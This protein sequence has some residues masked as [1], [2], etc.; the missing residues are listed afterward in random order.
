MDVIHLGYSPLWI[1]YL[2]ENFQIVKKL[3]ELGAEVSEGVLIDA[4]TDGNLEIVELF[5]KQQ[6]FGQF[7]P[8]YT[9]EIACKKKNLELWNIIWMYNKTIVTFEKL[10]VMEAVKSGFKKALENLKERYISFNFTTPHTTLELAVQSENLEIVKWLLNN[11]VDANIQR[12]LREGSM[13]I[14]LFSAI[15]ME[16]LELIKILLQHGSRVIQITYMI[17]DKI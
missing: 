8:M 1:A 12:S 5:L 2:H 9:V 16:N 17:L 14:Q 13:P 10:A 7:N 11:G 3:V 15:E 4:C 6:E